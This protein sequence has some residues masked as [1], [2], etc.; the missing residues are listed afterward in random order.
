MFEHMNTNA[1]DTQVPVEKVDLHHFDPLNPDGHC[2]CGGH[3]GHH[4]CGKHH[5]NHDN[6][7]DETSG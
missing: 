7:P 2:C 1:M 6:R 5:H 3:D 4:C